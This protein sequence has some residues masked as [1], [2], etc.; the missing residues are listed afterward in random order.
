MAKPMNLKVLQGTHQ[1][2]RDA[3]LADTPEFEPL[4]DVPE[5]PVW[6]WNPHAT[7]EWE[8]L[9]RI[10]VNNGLLTEGSIMPLAHL[11]AMHGEIATAWAGGD[12]PSVG[13]V[14]AMNGLIAAFGLTPMA[15]RKVAAGGGGKPASN[16]FGSNGK[17]S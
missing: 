1:K 13:M 3:G 17:R 9:G 16:K 11:C 12:T 14:T 15:S 2:C 6:M 7:A 10:L 4:A 5:P 8:R